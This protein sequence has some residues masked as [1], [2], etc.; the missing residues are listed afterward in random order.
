MPALHWAITSSVARPMNMVEP[1]TGMAQTL[2]NFRK[3]NQDPFVPEEARV[4]GATGPDKLV[5]H[6]GRHIITI[7][8]NGKKHRAPSQR[9]THSPQ[10]RRPPQVAQ[11][12]THERNHRP[13]GRLARRAG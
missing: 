10:E 3:L 8:R 13:A 2:Q 7:I 4:A 1:I 11:G 6:D 12:E 5:L 9:H